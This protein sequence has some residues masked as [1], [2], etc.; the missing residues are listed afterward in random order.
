MQYE[1]L[2][3]WTGKV[4]FTADIDCKDE[5]RLSLKIGLAVRWGHGQ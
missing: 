3:R 1:V 4:Q 5:E 2:N